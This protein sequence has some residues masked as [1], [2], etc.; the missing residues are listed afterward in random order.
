MQIYVNTDSNVDGSDGPASWFQAEAANA[1]ARF[2]DR[3]TRIEIHLRDDSAGRHSSDDHRCLIEARPAGMDPVI[4][5][6][7]ADT[8]EN[9]LSGALDKL[10]SLLSSK[11]ERLNDKRG[12]DSI[13]SHD[14]PG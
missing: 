6:E 5:T 9:A 1:L 14:G 7:H 11:F 12:R 13:R 10:V 8:V 2:E 3:L 4:V